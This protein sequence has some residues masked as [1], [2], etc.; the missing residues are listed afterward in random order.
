M[1]GEAP[2]VGQAEAPVAELAEEP[3]VGPAGAPAAEQERA[4]VAGRA[5]V[6][7][8]E[9]DQAAAPVPRFARRRRRMT[10]PPALPAKC[11]ITSGKSASRSMAACCPIRNS[12]N[13][14]TRSPKPNAI[15]KRGRA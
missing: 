6:Q 13:T 14:P 3:A 2:V 10:S 5:V 15:R 11:G 12:P 1:A 8:A 7:R 4:Q 9:A